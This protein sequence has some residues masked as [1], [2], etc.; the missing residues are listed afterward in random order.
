MALA[1]QTQAPTFAVSFRVSSITA[2]PA[3]SGIT[4]SKDYVTTNQRHVQAKHLHIVPLACLDTEV[5]AAHRGTTDKRTWST[6][7]CKGGSVSRQYTSI[8]VDCPWS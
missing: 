8:L 6:P 5:C 7:F 2:V 4:L 1:T 3:G